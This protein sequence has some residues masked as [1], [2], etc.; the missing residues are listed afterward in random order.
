MQN[1]LSQQFWEIIGSFSQTWQWVNPH[2]PLFT[3]QKCCQDSSYWD[4]FIYPQP[5]REVVNNFSP[6]VVA[7]SPKVGGFWPAMLTPWGMARQGTCSRHCWM[8]PTAAEEK[9][10]PTAQWL[11]RYGSVLVCGGTTKTTNLIGV[12]MI[13]HQFLGVPNFETDSYLFKYGSTRLQKCGRNVSTFKLAINRCNLTIFIGLGASCPR[14]G[15]WENLEENI[16][17]PYN[18]APVHGENWDRLC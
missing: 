18:I 15:W 7:H 6:N 9:W 4:G 14:I 16:W 1:A 5:Y 8:R 17:A 10:G 2:N 13:N 11:Q 12:M 3:S